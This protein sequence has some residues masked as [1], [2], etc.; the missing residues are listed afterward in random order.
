MSE[1]AEAKNV[2]TFISNQVISDIYQDRIT[3]YLQ[4][5]KVNWSF[6]AQTTS[7]FTDITQN[8]LGKWDILLVDA[9]DALQNKE[10]PVS[11]VKGNPGIVVGI[12]YEQ[13][14][15]ANLPF[16]DAIELKRPADIDEWL[17]MMYDLIN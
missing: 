8:S 5:E 16:P 2:I 17:S 4:P 12:I 1:R 10:L 3:K 14:P 13:M 9:T 15:P 6:T 7:A 11:F